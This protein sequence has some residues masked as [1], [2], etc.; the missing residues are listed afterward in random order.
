MTKLNS[1]KIRKIAGTQRASGAPVFPLMV[2]LFGSVGAGGEGAATAL[3]M[4][5]KVPVPVWPIAS[6]AVQVTAVVP[7]A[8]VEPEAGSH[9]TASTPPCSSAAVGNV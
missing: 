3:T 6:V 7:T 5:L 2:A 1:P 4:T 9:A 8:N